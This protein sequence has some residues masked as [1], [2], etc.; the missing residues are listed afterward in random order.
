MATTYLD[1]FKELIM[2]ANPYAVM[3]VDSLGKKK[4][5]LAFN[6][7]QEVNL[8]ASSTMTTYP[9]E[10]NEYRT[11]GKFRDPNVISVRGIIQRP[12]LAGQA[13]RALLSYLGGGKSLIDRTKAQ[14]EQYIDVI[15]R[16]DI[17]TKSGLYENY[18]LIGYEIPESLENFGYFEVIMDFQQNLVPTADNEILKR[19]ADAKTIFGGICSKIGLG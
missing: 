8:K 1:S 16:L 4:V 6:S 7:I 2:G 13:A 11:D 3:H 14:L 10:S 5:V 9:T 12:S 15:C 18:S 19:I 17:Q